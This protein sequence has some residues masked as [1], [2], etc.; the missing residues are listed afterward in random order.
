VSRHPEIALNMLA[1]VSDRLR[2][3]TVQI[4]NLSLKEIPSR[5]S[6]YFLDVLNEK[7]LAIFL[8]WI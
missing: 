4:E 5:L 1:V 6:A 8:P 7:E 3:F 2:Q